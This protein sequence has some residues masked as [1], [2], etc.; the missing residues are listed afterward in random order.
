MSTS[1]NK[2]TPLDTADVTS[3]TAASS[4][5]QQPSP[6]TGY[7]RSQQQKDDKEPTRISKTLKSV[8]DLSISFLT[9]DVITV[10]MLNVAF[11]AIGVAYFHRNVGF[12]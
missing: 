1:S 8:K 3:E 12:R 10:F 7:L 2:Y 6:Q 11:Y 9:K 4:S 5:S